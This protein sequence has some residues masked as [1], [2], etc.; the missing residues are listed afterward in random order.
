MKK[1]WVWILAGGA[2]ASQELLGGETFR[3]DINPALLYYQGFSL[4]PEL[5]QSDHDWL[6]TNEWR[7]RV[8]DERFGKLMTGFDN[9][10]KLFR[11][12]AKAEV[13]CDW[14]LDLTDGP[15]ALL[16]G[17]AKAKLAAQTARLRTMWDL[18]NGKP[19][20]ARDD[21][22]AAFVMARE[23]SKDRVLISTLVQFA[24]ENI[25]A[26]VIAENFYQL[27]ADIL[28]ELAEGMDAAPRQGLVADT[29]H[30]EDTSFSRYFTRRI[31]EFR[32]DDETRA[33]ARMREL[34]AKSLSSEEPPAVRGVR[35]E[36][37]PGEAKADRIIAAG[38]GTIEGLFGLFQ[39]L[40]PIYERVERILR[41]PASEYEKAMVEFQ[42]M[43]K[44]HP[45]P[46]VQEFFAVFDNCRRKEFGTQ[47]T[48]AMVRSAIAYKLRG[49]EG[50]RSVLDPCTGGPLE[51]ERFVFEGVD[52]GFKLKSKYRGRDF[53]EVL[54]FVEKPGPLFRIIGKNAGEK[55]K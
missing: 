1:I 7:G 55:V 42:E 11:R 16:P 23:V 43:V 8:L 51:F 44:T 25:V 20:E 6:Y 24:M 53:D 3:T 13:P 54:I 27:P 40:L 32:A 31:D 15:E 35:F 34:L 30:T 29:I 12:A 41:L 33:L 9:S 47:S 2:L 18:Q 5:S 17:L 4:R 36:G 10:F 48:L 46:L 19:A 50:F 26:S 37:S 38:G 28:S 21:L 14:G 45:N 52:R 49:D 22:L 39:E